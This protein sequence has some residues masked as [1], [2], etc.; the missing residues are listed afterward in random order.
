MPWVFVFAVVVTVVLA[1][2]LMAVVALSSGRLGGRR[3]A[4][5][6]RVAETTSRHLNGKG[7]PPKFLERLD[8][9]P[10]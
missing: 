8:E 1:L 10:E 5:W 4:K 2:G 9:R 7:Q 3:G 6:E